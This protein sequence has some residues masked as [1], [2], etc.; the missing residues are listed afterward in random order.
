MAVIDLIQHGT[1]AIN[2]AM[3]GWSQTLSKPFEGFFGRRTTALH[4]ENKRAAIL[5]AAEDERIS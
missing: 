3:A 2:T 4:L 1:E 5:A